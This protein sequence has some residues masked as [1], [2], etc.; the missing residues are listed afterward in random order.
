MKKEFN[1]YGQIRIDV[2]MDIEADSEAQ[3]IEKAKELFTD[4]YHLNVQGYYHTPVKDVELA[5]HAIE[6]EEETEEE[7]DLDYENIKD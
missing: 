5:I 6:Y 4:S 7:I 1:V 3:A 2:V